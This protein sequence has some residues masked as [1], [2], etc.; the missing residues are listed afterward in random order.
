MPPAL[1]AAVSGRFG[2]NTVAMLV[3]QGGRVLVQAAYFVIVARALGAE[4]F[5][6]FAGVVALVALVGPLAS[7]GVLN[8]MIR[9]GARDRAQLPAQYAT[10]LAVCLVTGALLVPALLL[11][12]PLVAPGEVTWA[13]LTCIAVA[14]LFGSRANELAAAAYQAAET[15]GRSARILLGLQV[16]RAAGAVA[17]LLSPA[18]FTLQSWALVYAASTLIPS[19]ISAVRAAKDVGFARPDWRTYRRDWK[20]GLL[21]SIGL[22]SQ[23]LYNDIDKVMLAKLS[24]LEATGI[25][26]AAYRLVDMAFIPARALLAAANP[27]FFREG[28]KGV[29]ATARLT[30]RLLAPGIGYCLFSAVALLAFADAVPLVLG[31]DY[32]ASVDALR[33]LAIIPLLKVLH[34]LP[35]DA[36]TGAD[37]QGTR[38]VAQVAAAGLNIGLNLALIPAHG[39]WGAVWASLVADG[40]LAVIMWI[41]L[42]VKVRRAAR[43]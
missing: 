1:R 39:Y 32:A 30:R 19:A 25:Y 13:V 31:S 41:I 6:A 34:Y 5:G 29:T 23:T 2:R 36:L 8:L 17:L 4:G 33:A 22:S 3:G 15:M 24:T 27:R 35:A 12:R 26:T 40:A 18:D 14:D 11:V 10:A 42:A 21:F 16:A 37:M 20:I 7:L 43:R 38:T 9:G 28:I